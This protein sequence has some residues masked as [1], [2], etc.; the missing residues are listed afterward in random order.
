MFIGGRSSGNE[1]LLGKKMKSHPFLC[2]ALEF[3]N[4]GKMSTTSARA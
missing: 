2:L 4:D 1:R 3:D